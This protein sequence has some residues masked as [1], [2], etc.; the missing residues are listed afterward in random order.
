M[1][2]ESTE[3]I[4]HVHFFLSSGHG[5]LGLGSLLL[6]GLLFFMGLLLGSRGSGSS[7]CGACGANALL[8]V[9]D[10][11]V[12]GLALEGVDNSL[13]VLVGSVRADGSKEGLDVISGWID[14]EVLMSFLPP[15][16][17]RA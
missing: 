8:S 2:S 4:A 3:E 13:D 5:L 15:R 12:E 16:A 1:T 6:L 11:L 7:G 17:N 9:S 14:L 10:Q